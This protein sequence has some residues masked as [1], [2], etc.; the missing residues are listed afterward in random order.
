MIDQLRRHDL[1]IVAF[2]TSVVAG[3]MEQNGKVL[4][5]RRREDQPHPLKWEFLGGKIEPGESPQTA[6]SR[7]MNEELSI[8]AGTCVELMRY[9]FPYSVK[10]PIL[11]IFLE[12]A[13]W[14]GQ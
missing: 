9:E 3:V 10:H 12:V 11:L 7:E 4:I 1:L 6:L 13:H 5:C 14:R 2:M 8:E